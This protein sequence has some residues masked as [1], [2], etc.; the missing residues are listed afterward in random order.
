ME[1]TSG[2]GD[3]EGRPDPEE[4]K[5]ETVTTWTCLNYKYQGFEEA[6]GSLTF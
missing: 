5:I 3:R 1:T 4:K 2:S 6:V